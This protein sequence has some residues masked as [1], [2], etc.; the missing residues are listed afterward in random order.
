KLETGVS[1]KATEGA[2]LTTLIVKH[3]GSLS[4][5]I[6]WQQSGLEIDT[7]YQQLK[8]EMA[9]GW[10]VESEPAFMKEVEAG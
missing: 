7:F 3:K 5:K 4:A 1:P 8:T 9:N 2:P 10:I 6:L